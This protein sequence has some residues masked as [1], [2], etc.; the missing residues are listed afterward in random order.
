MEIDDRIKHLEDFIIDNLLLEKLESKLNEFNIFEIL[1]IVETE[2]RHSNFLAWLLDPHENHGLGA[3][4]LRKFLSLFFYQNRNKGFTVVDIDLMSL[5]KVEIRREWKSIDILIIMKEQE[6]NFLFVIENKINSS[7]NNKQLVK[8]EEIIKTEYPENYKIFYIYL[9]PESNPYHPESSQNWNEFNYSTISEILESTIAYFKGILNPDIINILS[10]YLKIQKR[11]I[12]M[13][14]EIIKELCIN[15]WRKHKPA[16]DILLSYKNHTINELLAYT[17]KQIETNELFEKIHKTRPFY[18]TKK[19]D[20]IIPYKSNESNFGNRFLIYQLFKSTNGCLYIELYLVD[21]D[22][23]IRKNIFLIIK[24]NKLFNNVTKDLKEKWRMVYTKK[25]VENL[26]NESELELEQHKKN[27]EV[28]LQD[29][30]KSVTEIDEFIK[31][32]YK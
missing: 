22:Y 11:Y 16:L 2:I 8:Y 3:Y 23:E 32:N 1:G 13:E 29:F 18:S 19:I 17:Q 7:E 14:D 27:L 26:D 12:Q 28:E 24:K 4:F 9:V 25:L 5:R 10:Q 30:F 21:G 31:T 6:N 20:G 15:I